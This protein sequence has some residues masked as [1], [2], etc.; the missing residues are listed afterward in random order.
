MRKI[1]TRTFCVVVT[2]YQDRSVEDITKIFGVEFSDRWNFIPKPFTSGE[3]LQMAHNLAAD[4]DRRQREKAHLIQIK[5]QQEQLIQSE[6]LAAVGQLARGI[7]HEFGNILLSI[8]G[9]AELALQ[10]LEPE[11]M[12]RSLGI[13]HKSA[14]R[15]G[16]IVR[17][18]QG[19]VKVQTQKKKMSIL[20]PLK[21]SIE[22]IRHEFKRW[23]VNVSEDY[24]NPLS[25]VE[26][27][28]IEMGQVFLNLFINATHA[29]QSKGG[30]LKISAKEESSC[31]VLEISD[32]GVGL[33][34]KILKKSFCLFF[35]QR[36]VRAAVLDFL[37]SVRL[38]RVMVEKIGVRSAVGKGTTFRIEIPKS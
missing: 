17:N 20:I 30:E 26:I 16:V 37:W 36:G 4:W 2:A 14:E 27:N 23:K 13:I 1:E 11:E 3:I 31:L 15:A 35:Q 9:N 8:I 6:R 25:D 10:S 29:M 21:S 7:G 32:T 38:S 12:K 28:D 34:L 19:L 18:L 22:L 33:N 24:S 5:T